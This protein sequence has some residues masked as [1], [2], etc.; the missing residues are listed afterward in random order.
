MAFALARYRFRLLATGPIRLP[1]YPGSAWRGL[2]GHSLR[3]TVCVTHLPECGGCLLRQS[4]AYPYLFETPVPSTAEKLTRYPVAPHPFVLTVPLGGPA[5]FDPGAEIEVGMA[6]FGRA[7]EYLP[8]IVHAFS[9]AG[10]RG[11]GRGEGTFRLAAVE[12]ETPLAGGHWSPI[13]RERGSLAPSAPS[14]PAMPP[15]PT[16]AE[17][18]LLT[19]LRVKREGRLVGPEAFAFHDLYRA[20]LRR[21]SLLTYFHGERPLELDFRAWTQAAR[22]VAISAPKLRWHDWTRYSSRQRTTMEMGGLLGR[23]TVTGPELARF[24]PHLWLGQ[25]VHAGKGT[26]MGLGRYRIGAASLP[27]RTDPAC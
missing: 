27:A 8:Y 1:G 5:V 16:S 11:I 7:N 24:W 10:A 26:S 2:F 25:W 14:L 21:L 20:L 17:I 18:E 3:R 23:F 6:L 4:C 19:P 15:P 12:Q 13:Y 22:A 9:L